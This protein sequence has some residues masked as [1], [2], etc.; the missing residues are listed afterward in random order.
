MPD[1][2]AWAFAGGVDVL[3]VVDRAADGDVLLV[4]G[5]LAGAGVN[6]GEA[7]NEV[8]EA[9]GAAEGVEGVFLVRFQPALPELLRGANGGVPCLSTVERDEELGEVE[10]VRDVLSGSGTRLAGFRL[11]RRFRSLDCPR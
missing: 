1:R 2:A 6:D 11:A 3:D 9:V 8:E 10:E 5:D 4:A 7:A